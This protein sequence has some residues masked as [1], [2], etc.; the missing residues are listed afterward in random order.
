MAS[1]SGLLEYR[2]SFNRWDVSA[3]TEMY[4]MF[5]QATAFNWDI[6]GW[7]VSVVI[8]MSLMFHN[9]PISS[10]NKPVRQDRIIVG[11]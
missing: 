11:S 10:E 3:V 5:F 7:N 4:D 2:R 9:C 8:S 1:M 6:S